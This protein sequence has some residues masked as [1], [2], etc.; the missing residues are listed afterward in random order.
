MLPLPDPEHLS[1]TLSRLVT[2]AVSCAVVIAAA[3]ARAQLAGPTSVP[4]TTGRATAYRALPTAWIRLVMAFGDR[5]NADHIARDT[6]IELTLPSEKGERVLS[7]AHISSAE[8]LQASTTAGKLTFADVP[9]QLPIWLRVSIH[10][11]D[12]GIVCTYARSFVL[13][14][15]ER[16]RTAQIGIARA[17]DESGYLGDFI[18]DQAGAEIT[19]RVSYEQVR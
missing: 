5:G 18:V 19:R 6:T 3:P 16:A 7:A 13:H 14:F 8:D 9:T 15:P 1:K 11:K 2:T 4:A 17:V 10:A 12:G